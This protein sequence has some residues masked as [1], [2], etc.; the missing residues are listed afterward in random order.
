[1]R[2]THGLAL[3]F[4]L[5][6]IVTFTVLLLNTLGG[7][8]E[9]TV[10]ENTFQSADTDKDR[11]DSLG[12]LIKK[13]D[14]KFKFINRK[15]GSRDDIIDESERLYLQ[16]V[17]NTK[18]SEPKDFD[19]ESIR[20]PHDTS[21]YDHAKA[22]IFSV[23]RY[24]DKDVLAKTIERFESSFN[25]KFNYPYTFV[26]NKPFP[27][28]FKTELLSKTKAPMHF[29]QME[30]DLWEWPESIDENRLQREMDRLD[31][32]GVTHAQLRYYRRR[33]RFYLIMFQKMPELRRYKWYWRLDPSSDFFTDVKYDVF[34]YL[35][36]TGRIYGFNTNI[37]DEPHTIATLWKQT[38]KWLN[39][40][41]NYKFVNKNGA[42]QWLTEN[43]QH[44]GKTDFLGGYSSCRFFPS[45]EIG[46]LD[47]FRSEAYTKWAE[48]LES[49]GKFFY[50]AWGEGPVH[51]IALGLFADKKD[52][53]WFR[54]IGF[55]R[56]PFAYCPNSDSTSGCLVGDIFRPLRENRIQNCM[57]SWISNAMENPL[58]I[59]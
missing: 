37:Y 49:T 55:S 58:E 12:Y 32:L 56:L 16:L 15:K 24:P 27:D 44:P 13:N 59:Y 34:K 47:F 31:R 26:S 40:G 43:Q 46:N 21:N 33:C 20:P 30:Q 23:V 42:F 5:S 54:D 38:L 19:I 51:S 25:S 9:T 4:I 41:D 28:D 29:Y 2:N 57:A 53:H 17:R 7:V 14:V 1:M 11:L 6:I 22:T 18:V 3:A 52:I 10:Q 36:G 45:F 8:S 50:D 39:T 48:M 35:E